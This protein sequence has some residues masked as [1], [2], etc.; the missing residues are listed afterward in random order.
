M[1]NCKAALL[2]GSQA[3]PAC[4]SDKSSNKIK[5]SVERCCSGTYGKTKALGKKDLRQ[6]RSDNP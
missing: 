3:Y 2:E 5:T 1:Y 4:P 6:N